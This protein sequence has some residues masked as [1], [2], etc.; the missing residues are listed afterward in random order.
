M[1][2]SRLMENDISSTDSA[3]PLMTSNSVR[4]VGKRDRVRSSFH[5]LT[6]NPPRPGWGRGEEEPG[7]AERERERER[8]RG[9]LFDNP[10]NHVS[11]RRGTPRNSGADLLS[12]RAR[13]ALLMTL[14]T[15]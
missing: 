13:S 10:A 14:T 4:G 7:E 1:A 8:E 3:L 15:G 11:E 2:R 6:A 12:A 5:S 9:S